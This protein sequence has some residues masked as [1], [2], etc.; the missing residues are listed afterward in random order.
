M[1]CISDAYSTHKMVREEAQHGT[2]SE[3]IHVLV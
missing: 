1:L 2:F 3:P